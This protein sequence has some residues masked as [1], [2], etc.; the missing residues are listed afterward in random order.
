MSGPKELSER[1]PGTGGPRSEGGPTPDE[2]REIFSAPLGVM[3]AKMGVITPEQQEQ[4]ADRQA[5]MVAVRN[6][7]EMGTLAP[8]DLPQFRDQP[9]FLALAG[10]EQE[11]ISALLEKGGVDAKEL[12]LARRI[13]DSNAGVNNA[14]ETWNVPFIG[15]I[16]AKMHGNQAIAQA[17]LTVQQAIRA[18]ETAL[19][20]HTGKAD[21]ALHEGK[22]EFNFSNPKDDPRLKDA[23]EAHRCLSVM[24]SHAVA[25][26][27]YDVSSQLRGILASYADAATMFEE[28]GLGNLGAHVRLVAGSRTH[29]LEAPAPDQHTG[30][31]GAG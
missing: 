28:A 29:I 6:A 25:G 4:S 23:V 22:R 1:F 24:E 11:G 31:A 21:P 12:H 16:H 13:V 3:L 26:Q 19:R 2:L 20:L 17:A 10:M 15:Q 5:L 7:L 18:E 9:D 27:A 14:K 30:P 8:E